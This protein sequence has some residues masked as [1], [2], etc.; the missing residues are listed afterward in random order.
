MSNCY[1]GFRDIKA[2]IKYTFIGYGS[3]FILITEI[4]KGERKI[5]FNDSDHQTHFNITQR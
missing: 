1:E 5:I 4:N 2:K 3:M